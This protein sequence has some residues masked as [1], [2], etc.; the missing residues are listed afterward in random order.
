[1]NVYTCNTFHGHWPV[2]TAAVVVAKDEAEARNLLSIELL[3][4]GLGLS[5]FD[6]LVELDLTKPQATILNNGDY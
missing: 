5:D 4:Q 2:G 3:K 6:E 1:M